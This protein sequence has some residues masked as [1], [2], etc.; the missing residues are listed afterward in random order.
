MHNLKQSSNVPL[1]RYRAGVK[2]FIL[3]TNVWM[4]DVSLSAVGRLFQMT[5][6]SRFSAF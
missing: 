3:H 6:V 2:V 4:D 5:A 1:L